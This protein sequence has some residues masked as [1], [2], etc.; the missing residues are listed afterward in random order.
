M[1]EAKGKCKHLLPFGSPCKDCAARRP[2][3]HASC[4][5]YAA[6]RAKCDA[7]AEE[8]KRKTEFSEYITDTMKRFPGKRHI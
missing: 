5:A 7:L 6:Y 3:C 1:G 4:E 8:R 2:H